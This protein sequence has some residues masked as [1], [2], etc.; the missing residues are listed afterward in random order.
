MTEIIATNQE[1]D[2]IT[3]SPRNDLWIGGAVIGAFFLLFLGWAAFAPL[4]AGAFAQ[5]RVAISGNRQSVQHREGGTVSAL[6]VSEG[7]RVRRGQ[8]L[9]ELA[10]GELEAQERGV[11]GQVFALL[12]Q[13]ARLIAERDGLRTIVAPTEFASLPAEDRLLADEALRLQRFQFS[14]RR[15]GR[16]TETGVMGQRIGQLEQ[17]AAGFQRQI[18]SNLEQRRLIEEELDGLKALAARGFAPQNRV[19]GLERTA[20]AL[21]GELG[22]LRAQIARTQ[23]AVG[24]TRLEMLGISTK[25][26]EDVADQLR[27]LEVQLNELRP[28]LNELRNQIARSQIRAPVDGQVVGLTTFTQGGVVAAGQTL[29]DIVPNQASQ[30]IVASVNPADIDNLR[31]GLTTE[32]KFPGLRDR[33]TPILRGSVTRLSA[34][35][36]SDEKTGH[37]YYRAEVVIPAH[38]LRQL[39]RSASHI[40]AGMPVEV[41][42]VLKKRTALQYLIDPLTNS[43]WR[44]GSEE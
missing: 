37:S 8:V 26:N 17:Q 28:R 34:D 6:H 29:M 40:R 21:D 2:P 24:E 27:L 30:L 9:I 33:A 31:V 43:L 41:V 10:T 25:M 11:A 14:A 4:D 15:N 42:V 36:F 32:V 18:E 20:A 7:D 5:G 13:R 35:S 1:P 16:S 19:R 44:T 22:S 38:E 23:E 39:G 12:S 3:D